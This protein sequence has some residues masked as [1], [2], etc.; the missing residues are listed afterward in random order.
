MI[1]IMYT[2]CKFHCIRTSLGPVKL[3]PGRLGA[4]WN[5]PW[6]FP[7][8]A[9]VSSPCWTRTRRL[10]RYF[11]IDP[12]KKFVLSSIVFLWR[13]YFCWSFRNTQVQSPMFQFRILD[14]FQ[15]CLLLIVCCSCSDIINCNNYVLVLE[16]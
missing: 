2:G 13:L 4:S 1:C 16:S 3:R 9:N 7:D 6:K 10:R 11:N 14:L 15:E 5:F 8:A 12:W